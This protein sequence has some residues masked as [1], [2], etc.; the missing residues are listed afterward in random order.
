LQVENWASGRKCIAVIESSSQAAHSE[1]K[2]SIYPR[3]ETTQGSVL[4]AQLSPQLVIHLFSTFKN[5][6]R[7]LKSIEGKVKCISTLIVI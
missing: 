5:N 2:H 1:K 3:E 4:L 7:K 6:F